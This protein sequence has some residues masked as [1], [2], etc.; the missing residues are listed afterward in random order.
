MG[1]ITLDQ[2]Q[3][4]LAAASTILAGEESTSEFKH[5]IFGLLFYKRISDVYEEEYA[6]ILAEHDDE[7]L[8][9]DR[10]FHRFQVPD[11][12]FWRD[13][14]AQA[15]NIGEKLNTTLDAV[16][17]A[18]APRLDGVFRELDFNDKQKYPDP[19]LN[20]LLQ[21]LSTIELN[22]A[23]VEAETLGGAFEA[24]IKVFADTEGTKGGKFFTPR[25]VVTLLMCLIDP[26]EGE[27][28]YDPACGTAGMLLYAAKHVAD[29]GGDVRKLFLY[30]QEIIH[31][32]WAIG[33]MN[34]LLHE[35]EDVQ[36]Q[37]GDSLRDPKFRSASN[38]LRT[39]DVVVSN[40]EFSLK[41]WG[42]KELSAGDP[43]GR[44][45]YGMPPNKT[46]DYAWVQH[47]IASMNDSGRAAIVMPNGVL[48]RPWSEG[49]IRKGIVEEDLIEAVIGLPKNVFYGTTISVCSC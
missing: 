26:K 13:V 39:F 24:Q 19:K 42:R 30:G 33:R 16:A 43:F 3:T 38:A 9:R 23:S 14:R 28:I 6:Q 36:L 2:L 31:S 15:T 49:R 18:N 37:R 17:R 34:M 22:S 46:G 7:T 29:S 44:F 21:Q 20:S 25:S 10:S 40:P 47:I 8:A 12:C 41:D 5:H 48:F 32:N 1:K 11:G 4:Y 27:H 35:V 45:T